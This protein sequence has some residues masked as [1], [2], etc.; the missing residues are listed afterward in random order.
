MVG[1]PG[2]VA[3]LAL[4]AATAACGTI[5]VDL[6]ERTAT[7]VGTRTQLVVDRF[8]VC[9]PGDSDTRAIVDPVNPPG[10]GQM[11]A[12]YAN[13]VRR[14]QSCHTQLS[15]AYVA[16]FRFDLADISRSVVTSAYLSLDRAD[17]NLPVHVTRDYPYGTRIERGCMLNVQIAT[18]DVFSGTSR[19]PVSS[20]SIPTRYYDDHELQ[21]ADGTT[22]GGGGLTWVVQQWAL[23]RLPNYG[24]V[25]RPK[26]GTLDKNEDSCTGYWFN[27]RLTITVLRPA[28]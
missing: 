15:H 18:E 2:H 26:A 17:T 7:Q 22:G 10:A 5:S 19:G 3:A 9:W 24:L 25:I 13:H 11:I 8:G 20:M 23:G 6:P 28:P 1:K 27:P 12:G 14:G 16:A 4:V 21:N